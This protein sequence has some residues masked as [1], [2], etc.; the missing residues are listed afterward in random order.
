MPGDLGMILGGRVTV[1]AGLGPRR[2]SKSVF[3]IFFYFLSEAFMLEM[4]D[5]TLRWKP[6]PWTPLAWCRAVPGNLCLQ[7]LPAGSGL[8]SAS[9][10]PPARKGQLQCHRVLRTLALPP[11]S[12]LFKA[13]EMLQ[14]METRGRFPGQVSRRGGCA[15]SWSPEG[16]SLLAGAPVPS[17]ARP[18]RTAP[19]LQ[20]GEA[21]LWMR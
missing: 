15:P 4:A 8:S 21:E 2:H 10:F 12:A 19:A 1:A 6:C 16:W 3:L 7:L 14:A 9:S 13:P 17:I 18:D 5:E 20:G 11:R